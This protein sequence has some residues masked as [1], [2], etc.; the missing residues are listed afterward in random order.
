[1][2]VPVDFVCS[3]RQDTLPA[4]APD[5]KGVLPNIFLPLILLNWNVEHL[6]STFVSCCLA[7]AQSRGRERRNKAS[8]LRPVGCCN[9][10]ENWWR[11]SLGKGQGLYRAGSAEGRLAHAP[12]DKLPQQRQT[13]NTVFV[14]LCL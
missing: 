5:L 4:G 2:G 13:E 14:M 12:V 8:Q 1:M 10:T 6:V 3:Q 9:V 7:K 11:L